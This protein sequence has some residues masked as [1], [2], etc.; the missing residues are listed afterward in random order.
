MVTVHRGALL[1]GLCLM[2]LQSQIADAQGGRYYDADLFY[3][4]P[5]DPGVPPAMLLRMAANAGFKGV[6]TME[7]IQVLFQSNQR[8]RMA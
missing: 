2:S 1:M 3:V 6:T 4:N 7:D 8:V 5:M